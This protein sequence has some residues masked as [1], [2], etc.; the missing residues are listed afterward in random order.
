MKAEEF[1][2]IFLIEL[3]SNPNLRNYYK[4]LE[5]EARFSFRKAY[6]CQRLEYVKNNLDNFSNKE[7]TIWDCGCGY[8][9][10]AIFLAL[11]GYRVYGN[12]LEFYFKEIPKRL[13]FWKQH[14]NMELFTY[15]Y[16]NLFDSP[17]SS[18]SI[19]VIIVQDTLHHLEPIGE[20]LNIFEKALSSNGKMIVIE[21]NGNNII[22]R[23]KLFLQR[24]NK[25]IIEIDDPHLDKKILLGNENIRSLK[26]WEA[27]LNKQ[28]MNIV[29]DSINYIRY[30][31]PFFF[32]A[33]GENQLIQK[34]QRIAE[35]D[36][37]RREYFF[38]G[39][40]FIAKKANK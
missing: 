4:F 7:L 40:N 19:D 8:G 9:T 12:T 6:F 1:F 11:N 36:T 33:N 37:W 23:I 24:G 15:S 5:N 22:Q 26:K 28:N 20:A 38:F 16:S 10:T 31:L 18:E 25:R 2:D 17:P 30:Y 21:E 39:I 32:K 13:E 14:G 3:R 29:P 27:E 34:E 35:R